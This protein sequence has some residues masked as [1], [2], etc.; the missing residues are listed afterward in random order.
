VH[1][2]ARL[3]AAVA[4]GAAIAVAFPPFWFWPGVFVGTTALTLAVAGARAE[5]ALALGFAAG[6]VGHLVAFE[7]LGPV[8]SRFTRA[9]AP[10]TGMHVA[11]F[12]IYQATQLALFAV[13][14]P[15]H[16]DR[17]AGWARRSAET[18]AAWVVAEWGFPKIIPWSLA[19]GLAAAT[20]LRQAGDI[21]GPHG[22]SFVVAAV[23]ATLAATL[24]TT[25][26]RRQ[27]WH[28]ALA[29]GV[30]LSAMT[31][32]GV[33]RVAQFTGQRSLPTLRVTL[34]QGQVGLHDH[35]LAQTAAAWPVYERLTLAAAR[36]TDAGG[37]VI[38][39]ETILR[40]YIRHD[41][42][43]LRRVRSLVARIKQPLLLGA[44]DL[45][46]AGAGELNVAF[47][48]PVGATEAERIQVYRKRWLLP[49]A[50]YVPAPGIVKDWPTTGNFVGGAGGGLLDL[51]GGIALAPA[52]CFEALRPGVYNAYV[53]AG[54]SL[55]ANLSD[56][57]WFAGTM[58]PLQHLGVATMRAVETRRWL[59]RSSDSGISAVV[60]PTGT[61]V[62][63]LEVGAAGTLQ[64]DVP[65]ER[66][67]TPYV[68]LGDWVILPSAALV[69]LR[70]R[71]SLRANAIQA[72]RLSTPT[73]RTI[74][75]SSTAA[76]RLNA[77]GSSRASDATS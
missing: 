57:G 50:E 27:R 8:L 53:R 62:R 69:T 37:I 73:A 68:W 60:D 36:D 2:V 7:W 10:A 33:A 71:R 41:E 65:L 20:A 26:I 34:V 19:D 61:I 64:V 21:G 63:Q 70:L 28:A 56:D 72:A 67:H 4:G 12:V 6:V 15:R 51:G 52:I 44:L 58:A 75:G 39:P 49:F 9:S 22:L 40:A 54:A 25:A 55:L 5:L 23:G 74:F 77:S 1:A 35:A 46:A 47:L 43:Q 30:A 31:L 29:V 48:V 17:R 3:L 14:A 18:A 66:G 16:C 45:P 11:A 42:R 32:Y 59:V 13:L 24:D 38:W 76:S